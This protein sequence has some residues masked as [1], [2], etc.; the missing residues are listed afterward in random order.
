MSTP[1]PDHLG[2]ALTLLEEI[3]AVSGSG[4]TA[5]TARKVQSI[6]ATSAW[7][8]K[9]P[10]HCRIWSPQQPGERPSLSVH[11][12]RSC[13][14][15]SSPTGQ[16]PEYALLSSSSSEGLALSPSSPEELV[17]CMPC[18]ALPSFCGTLMLKACHVADDKAGDGGAHKQLA[19][20]FQEAISKA[21]PDLNVP[22]LIAPTNQPE[23][24]DYQCNNAMSLF[25]CLKGKVCGLTCANA[26][27][28]C[29]LTTPEHVSTELMLLS[30][31][32][33]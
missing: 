21:Y 19:A 3:L 13:S 31:T 14:C 8:A 24:G 16:R 30:E 4:E 22:A 9:H 6:S 18:A 23:H 28:V 10:V 11:C 20:L 25:G 2:H 33:C 32:A 17:L 27:P 7:T 26:G 12:S 29:H 15:R 5:T 1:A